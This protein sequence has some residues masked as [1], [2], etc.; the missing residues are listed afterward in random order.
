MQEAVPDSQ[1]FYPTWIAVDSDGDGI[2]DSVIVDG[3]GDGLQDVDFHDPH[4][5]FQQSDTYKNADYDTGQTRFSLLVNGEYNLQDST[6]STV[7]FEGLYASR[8]TPIYSPGSQLFPTVP[9]DNP[10]NPCGTNGINCMGILGLDWGPSTA[11]PIINIHGDRD[12][13]KIELSQYRAV[14]GIKGNAPILE[15]IGL[16]NWYYDVYLSHSASDGTN[17]LQGLDAQRLQHSLDTTVLN[18][19][20]SITCGDGSDGCVPVNLF[21][22][23]IYQTGGGRLTPEEEEYLFVDRV[24]KTEVSQ[25]VFNAFVGGDLFEL[26]WNNEAVA[27]IFGGEWRKDKIESSPNDVAQQGLLENYFADKGA[28]GTRF[29]RELFVEFEAPLLRGQPWAEELTF[30]ASGR[31]S[32]ESF[33]AT[34][35]TYSLKAVY[36]PVD[37]LTLR[38]TQGT[39]YR[40][41]NL[42]ERFLNGTTGFVTVT[43]PCTV[44]DLARIESLTPGTPD[45]YDASKDERSAHALEACRAQGLD[46]LSLGLGPKRRS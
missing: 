24:M 16:E 9:A 37:W 19:D 45:I 42:R 40:A 44:P 46:P 3:N 8:D 39:S 12:R 10:F 13:A 33:Y 43:D 36:R 18:D 1:V 6:D 26:P 31:T 32:D 29:M 38:G 20:G 2:N 25:T 30:T 17:R 27:M 4:Y 23:N 11:D 21:A 41:P 34:A 5:S 22:E 14:S 35:N 28:D 7:Y 15:H